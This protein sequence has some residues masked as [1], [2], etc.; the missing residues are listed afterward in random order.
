M[1]KIKYILLF[2]I[3]PTF[4]LSADDTSTQVY[5]NQ[6]FFSFDPNIMTLPEYM[7]NYLVAIS[8][9]FFTLLILFQTILVSYQYLTSGFNMQQMRPVFFNFVISLSIATI[10]VFLPGVKKVQVTED[11]TTKI[12]KSRLIVD[13]TASLFAAGSRIADMFSYEVLFGNI[14]GDKK[15]LFTKEGLMYAPGKDQKL[16][17][18]ISKLVEQ[19][20]MNIQNKYLVSTEKVPPSTLQIFN[21][22][23]NQLSKSQLNKYLDLINKIEYNIDLLKNMRINIETDLKIGNTMFTNYST[24]IKSTDTPIT[25]SIAST[26]DLNEKKGEFYKVVNTKIAFFYQKNIFNNL[27]KLKNLIKTNF[28]S[29]KNTP[30]ILNSRNFQPYDAIINTYNEL[31]N[32]KRSD[33]YVF[34]DNLEHHPNMIPNDKQEEIFKILQQ[35]AV[36]PSGYNGYSIDK[37]RIKTI[38]PILAKALNQSEELVPNYNKYFNKAEEVKLINTYPREINKLILTKQVSITP[39]DTIINRGITAIKGR[40]NN[41]IA[42]RS[43]IDKI[44]TLIAKNKKNK[45]WDYSLTLNELYKKSSFLQAFK[46][47]PF[48]SDSM[49]DDIIKTKVNLSKDYK[50]Y[51][52]D[53]GKYF[54]GL[55]LLVSDQVLQN[56]YMNQLVIDENLNSQDLDEMISCIDNPSEACKT[57]K[58]DT[59]EELKNSLGT[60]SKYGAIAALGVGIFTGVLSKYA[61]SDKFLSKIGAKGSSIDGIKSFLGTLIKIMIAMFAFFFI[62][63]F[64]NIIMPVLFWYLGVINWLLKSSILLVTMSFTMVFLILDNRRQQVI[65]NIFVVLGQAMIPLFMVGI[66]FLIVYMSLMIDIMAFKFVPS[67]AI[68]QSISNIP[69]IPEALVTILTPLLNLF[70]NGVIMIITTILNFSLFRYLFNV[71]EFVSEAIGAQVSNNIIQPDKIIQNFGRNM[72]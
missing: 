11:G 1:K 31:E 62:I 10:L 16:N 43:K 41:S 55:K 30:N 14:T 28:E 60:V 34:I 66:F 40:K 59:N 20:I 9:Y 53:L 27:T 65:N 72:V 21:N 38:V 52:F 70:I 35:Q 13:L 8:A 23:K 4:L 49:I 15:N 63:T 33:V 47:L 61:G 17:G 2:L 24:K 22:L 44:N 7:A 64:A 26:D 68:S 25:K 3:I 29:L 51:W 19:N 6:L 39:L 45:T 12:V 48:V 5:F 57:K 67:V 42:I 71:D 56:V 18:F 69:M 32:Y 54:T 46:T 58:F 37:I 50:F 36:S